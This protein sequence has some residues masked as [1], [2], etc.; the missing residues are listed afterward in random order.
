[1]I[2]NTGLTSQEILMTGAFRKPLGVSEIAVDNPLLLWHS[3]K[4]LRLRR[5]ADFAASR[6]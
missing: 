3:L 2:V 6:R 5:S 4:T 1:M